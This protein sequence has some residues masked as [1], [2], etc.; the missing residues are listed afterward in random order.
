MGKVFSPRVEVLLVENDVIANSNCGAVY[1]CIS[2]YQAGVTCDDFTCT[3][4]ECRVAND[5]W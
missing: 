1:D 4:Y 2:C 3:G 5:D